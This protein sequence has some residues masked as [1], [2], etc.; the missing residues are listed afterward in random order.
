MCFC[1][2]LIGVRKSAD[3]EHHTH[4]A[5][6]TEYCRQAAYKQAQLALDHEE[7]IMTHSQR[8]L[9]NTYHSHPYHSLR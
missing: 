9:Y 2:I 4:G 6:N 5:P 7:S 3:D 1:D 8:N